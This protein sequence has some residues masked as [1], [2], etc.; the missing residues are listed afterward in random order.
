MPNLQLH[1]G[2]RAAYSVRAAN[3]VPGSTV[4][5]KASD[6]KAVIVE[7]EDYEPVFAELHDAKA[8]VVAARG[9][10]VGGSKMAAG[11]EVVATI[12]HP[13]GGVTH[14]AVYVVDVVGLPITFAVQ[15]PVPMAA[16]P[17]R[18]KEPAPRTI[19]TEEGRAQADANAAKALE[20][21]SPPLREEPAAKAHDPYAEVG[22]QH[23][24][25]GT[26]GAE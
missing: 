10:L 25:A 13:D 12:T 9:T 26:R 19:L 8:E 2:E 6:A 1:F 15:E 7:P 4:A 17:I 20:R 5:V 24:P 21:E 14:A 23:E 16:Q 18:L 3:F 22:M 11:V